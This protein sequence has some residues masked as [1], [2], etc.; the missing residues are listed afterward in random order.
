MNLPV[1]QL[2]ARVLSGCWRATPPP[3]EIDE[4]EWPHLTPLLIG[5]G[6]GALAWRR[7]RHGTQQQ[8]PAVAA[9]REAHH[10]QALRAMLQ[11]RQIAATFARLHQHQVAAILLKGWSSARQYPEAG[12]RPFGDIDLLV[13]PTQKALAGRVLGVSVDDETKAEADFVDTK[14]QLRPIYGFDAAQ[15]WQAR[16]NVILRDTSISL[17][18]EEDQL[19]MLCL[20]FLRHGAWRPLWLCDIA[21]ALETRSGSFD[22]ERCLSHNHRRADAI[23][24]A[25]GLAHQL[26]DAHIDDTP[27]AQ[28]ARALPRWLVPAVLR[29]WETP[30]LSQHT[31]P[32]LMQNL[33]RRG[34]YRRAIFGRW[35]NAIEA[36][37]ML[38][39]PLNWPPLPAQTIY[40]VG[41][42]WH[43]LKRAP[44]MTHS[45]A[46][47][48]DNLPS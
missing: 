24:C 25:L 26:L 15:V 4:A 21:V 9:L 45:A 5:S 16:Q 11:E 40:F 29:Q 34:R 23:A 19:R 18:C 43:F 38:R 1:S 30:L 39:A 48:A 41:M 6:A 10:A 42:S 36:A 31:A 13:Q 46:Q 35:P 44:K 7:L 37:L 47:S 22:W 8:L 28:R 32:E 20:H 27:V 17:L 2:L 33:L 12:L 14:S 3:V